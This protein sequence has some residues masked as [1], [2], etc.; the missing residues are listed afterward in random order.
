LQFQVGMRISAPALRLAAVLAISA[1]V[2]G[3]GASAAR[4]ERRVVVLDFAGTRSAM[5]QRDVRD[6]LGDRF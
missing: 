4:A 2:V 1:G 6:A 5:L 3:G